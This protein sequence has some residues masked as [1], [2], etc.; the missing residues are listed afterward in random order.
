MTEFLAGR[1]VLVVED[2]MMVLINI[3]D[4]LADFGCTSV[5]V[6]A[7]VDQALALIRTQDF[8][9]AVIDVN[10]DGQTSYPIADALAK[11]GVPFVFST[12]YRDPGLGGDHSDRPVLQ[13]PYRDA[14]LAEV[15]IRLLET[16]AIPAG[17]AELALT[18]GNQI[19]Q[20]PVV[21]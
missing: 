19:V 2:E 5:A 6:A 17:L 18:R 4:A 9:V 12:G 14:Q 3:E 20:P 10:L 15:L 1:R 7:T 11:R 13:K 16:Q 8:D 21:A